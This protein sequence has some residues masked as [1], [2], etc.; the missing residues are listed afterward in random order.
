MILAQ[1]LLSHGASP[2]TPDAQGE[3]PLQLAQKHGFSKIVELLENHIACYSDDKDSTETLV[4][5]CGAYSNL[6]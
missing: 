4:G 1:L 6:L 3:T 5:D 2:Q